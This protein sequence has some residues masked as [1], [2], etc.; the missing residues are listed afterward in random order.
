M[1]RDL[2]VLPGLARFTS[3]ALLALRLLTG[4]FLIHGVWDNV[5][6]AQRMDEFVGFL[7]TNGFPAPEMLAP[8]SAWTQLIA[9]ALL[10]LG[11]LTR[12]AGLIIALTFVVAVIGVHWYQSFRE[13][14]PAIAR[15]AI[16]FVFATIGP[17]GWSLDAMLA[18]QRR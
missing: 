2:L 18:R 16:G 5:T 3:L 17:G 6:S 10:V 11:L 15:A 8:L 1:N 7:A 13:W 12:W 4:G 14:W 9:G